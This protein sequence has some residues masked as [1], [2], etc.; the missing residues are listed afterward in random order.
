M[1]PTIREEVQ[2]LFDKLQAEADTSLADSVRLTTVGLFASKH[3]S[4]TVA[5]ACV[6]SGWLT[7]SEWL[8]QGDAAPTA[9]VTVCSLALPPAGDDQGAYLL[10]GRQICSGCYG[11]G[12]AARAAAQ[13]DANRLDIVGILHRCAS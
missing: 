4:P 7:A 5:L 10:D 6:L 8:A 12:P 1:N 11:D 3:S 9:I 13:N 2:G